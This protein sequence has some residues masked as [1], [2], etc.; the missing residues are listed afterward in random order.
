MGCD[1]GYTLLIGVKLTSVEE[2]FEDIPYE[3]FG[4]EH[5]IKD[6]KF[7]PQ[8]GR[9]AIKKGTRKVEKLPFDTEDWRY[10]DVPCLKGKFYVEHNME[11]G[12]SVY[13][14][15]YKKMEYL[16]TL[17]TICVSNDEYN[18]LITIV[19]E[20]LIPFLNEHGVAFEKDSIGIHVIPYID[21]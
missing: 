12:D 4:C 1:Y 16:E 3:E 21:C 7:C 15:V 10:T 17:N 5:K 8:C 9:K 2:L 13:I 14:G 6:S 18:R 20:E 19:K 11:Y